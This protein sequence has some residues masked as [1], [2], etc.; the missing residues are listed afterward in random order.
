MIHYFSPFLIASAI[1]AAEPSLQSLL[2]ALPYTYTDEV[3]LDKIGGGQTN[4]NY[5]ATIDLKSYFIRSRGDHNK[6]LG[7]SLEKEWICTAIAS[8]AGIAPR[9]VS[10]VPAEG[11]MVCEFIESQKVDLLA[12]MTMERYGALLRSLHTLDAKFPSQFCPFECIQ[13]L[14]DNAHEVKAKL[15]EQFEAKILPQVEALR[16][17]FIPC[18]QRVPCH[19]DLHQGNV[20]DNGHRMWLIDWEYAAMADPF[21][22]LAT[23]ASAD[24][25]TKQDMDKFLEVYLGRVPSFRERARFDDMR[26]LADVR[27][28]LWSYI[29]A[30]ISELDEPFQEYGD[31]FLKLYL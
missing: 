12:P 27:W 29:Q 7:S 2:D 31:A 8:A 21:F 10:Y 3:S 14:T 17:K 15:P 6:L 24:H 1:F 4:Q 23:L 11:I 9:V 30:V 28:A 5:K 26:F 19:L 22:D 16:K 18:K 25:F 20:L 13:Q